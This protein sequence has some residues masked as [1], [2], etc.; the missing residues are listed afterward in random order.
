MGC[1]SKE[2]P[3]KFGGTCAASFSETVNCQIHHMN[4][5]D[6]TAWGSQVDSFSHVTQGHQTLEPSSTTDLGWTLIYLQS[7]RVYS[8]PT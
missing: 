6:E 8:Y 7:I 2:F 4:R 1:C 5:R 3:F